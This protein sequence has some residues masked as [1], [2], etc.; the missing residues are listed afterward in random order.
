MFITGKDFIANKR[1]ELGLSLGAENDGDA[2]IVLREPTTLEL[3][4][5]QESKEAA[6]RK[7]LD[8]IPALLMDH[9]FYE[10]ETKRMDAQGVARTLTEKPAAAMKVMSEY[11][12]FV[13]S[14]FQSATGPK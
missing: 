11:L 5:L 6:G 3:M 14:P 13:T 12:A 2:F 8:M 7:L 10:T 9:D 1:I 4:D